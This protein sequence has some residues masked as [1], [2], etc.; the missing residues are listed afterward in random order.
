MKRRLILSLIIS[1]AFLAILLIPLIE[2]IDWGFVH[3]VSMWIHWPLFAIG[4]SSEAD[5]GV[6]LFLILWYSV[7]V[8]IATAFIYY[9]IQA[10]QQKID[11]EQ[12]N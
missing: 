1:I 10:I 3:D 2:F 12:K 6:I 7:I 11:R 5:K 8:G 4:S 9:A